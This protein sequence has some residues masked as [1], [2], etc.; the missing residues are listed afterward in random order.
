MVEVDVV[1]D[2]VPEHEMSHHQ[3][4]RAQAL[5]IARKVLQTNLMNMTI[6]LRAD[7]LIKIARYIVGDEV[8]EAPANAPYPVSPDAEFVPSTDG[9]GHWVPAPDCTVEH[10][11]GEENWRPTNDVFIH[12]HWEA[13]DEDSQANGGIECN[14]T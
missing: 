12:E 2:K 9:P 11:F 5:M 6:S 1:S 8:T 4:V 7:E 14:S 3:A 10:E 13:T